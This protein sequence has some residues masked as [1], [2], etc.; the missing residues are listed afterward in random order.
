M[1][2]WPFI[3]GSLNKI[4]PNN[5]NCSNSNSNNNNCSNSNSNNNN[6]QLQ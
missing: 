1:S 5:Y 6:K 3:T 2:M 4:Q